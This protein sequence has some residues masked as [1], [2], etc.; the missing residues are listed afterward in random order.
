[1]KQLF[2]CLLVIALAACK[3][4]YTPPFATPDT[5]YLVVEG[6][7]NKGPGLTL[8]ELSRTNKLTNANKKY[9][10]G[11]KVQ[12]EGDDNSTFLLAE[13][14]VGGY[15]ASLN[16][17][18]DKKYR[19]RIKT[20]S[21]KEYLSDFV[22]VK[23]TP[24]VDSISWQRETNGV[25]LNIN[26]HDPQNKSTYYQWD[27]QETWEFHSAYRS[28]LKYTSTPG[29]FGGLVPGIAFIDPV[30]HGYDT[31]IWKCWRSSASN[32]IIVGSSANLSRDVIFK[33]FLFINE[34]DRKISELYSIN[35]RQYVITKAGYEFLEKMKTNTEQ[36]G[37]IFDAQPSQLQGNIHC[38]S[39]ENE[40]VVGYIN[41]CS[42]E[43]KRLFIKSSDVPLWNFSTKCEEW[44]IPNIKDSIL[45]AIQTGNVPTD[46][47]IYAGPAIVRFGVTTVDCINCTLSGTNVKPAFWPR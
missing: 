43:E 8:I 4:K 20:V 7:I 39:D 12:V 2:Y 24:P 38:V 37:S 40:P 13:T 23:I 32:Q 30:S 33:P 3:E 25:Q 41:V 18:N 31:A 1:M 42:V 22:E 46:G 29:P 9:E 27:Y 35:L 17:L 44:S 21:G 5:G 34:G 6:V 19:L 15:T 10:R 45:D 26:T 28:S 16:L 36:I 47:L 14:G 11:A